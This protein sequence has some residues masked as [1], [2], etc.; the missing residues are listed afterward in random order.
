M[1]LV[2]RTAKTTSN[3]NADRAYL[4]RDSNQVNGIQT[5]EKPLTSERNDKLSVHHEWPPAGYNEA[6]RVVKGK[7]TRRSRGNLVHGAGTA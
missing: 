4:T 3:T 7:N 1:S 2:G 6:A 5:T